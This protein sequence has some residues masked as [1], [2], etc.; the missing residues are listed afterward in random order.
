MVTNE[1][2]GEITDTGEGI[3]SRECKTKQTPALW[4]AKQ[5]CDNRIY[6]YAP[7]DGKTNLKRNKRYKAPSMA[8]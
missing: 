8:K 3:R 1:S 5:I 4:M 7:V 2:A 6:S